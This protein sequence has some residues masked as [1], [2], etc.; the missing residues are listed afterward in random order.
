MVRGGYVRARCGYKVLSRLTKSPVEIKRMRDK[1]RAGNGYSKGR[2]AGKKS[3]KFG[4]FKPS[5]GAYSPLSL[6]ERDIAYCHFSKPC[7]EAPCQLLLPR[8]D[9]F[10]LKH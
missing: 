5:R 6:S 7:R 8:L 10:L 9:R 3:P 1:E 2:L 4:R